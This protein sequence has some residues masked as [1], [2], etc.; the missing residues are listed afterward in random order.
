M[1][2]RK[3]IH[4]LG[5]FLLVIGG[6]C[7]LSLLSGCSTTKNTAAT[8]FYH[9]LTTRY[10]VL[11]HG[12]NA[13]DQ[14]YKNLI[15]GHKETYSE[16]IISDPVMMRRGDA[17]AGE[18]K[19]GPF[20]KSIEKGRKAI[21]YHSIRVKPERKRGRLSPKEEEF[22]NRKEFNSYL[23]HAWML[24]AKSQFYN[25][26]F[27]EAMASFAYIA[28]LYNT[29]P[30]IRDEARL[31]QARCYVA[32]GWNL[33]SQRILSQVDTVRLSSRSSVYPLVRVELALA[34]RDVSSAL[35]Y[36]PAA[37]KRESLRE[38]RSRLNFLHGQLLLLAEQSSLAQK[39]F[40]RVIRS[41][42]PYPLEFA[43]RLQKLRIQAGRSSEKVI[44]ELNRM[45]RS[46]KN[47]DFL[48]A[49]YL[50]KGDL[51]LQKK[52]T[53]SAVKAYTNGAEKST[54]KLFDYVLCELRR[55]DL[56]LFQE[57]FMRAQVAFSGAAAAISRQHESYDRVHTLSAQLDELSKHVKVVHEQDSLRHLASL[58]EAER[59][60]VIDSAIVT[61]KKQKEEEQKALEQQ[62]QREKQEQFNQEVGGWNNDTSTSSFPPPTMASD[63]RFYFYNPQLIAQGKTVFERK[64]GK[65]SLEDDWRRRTKRLAP[66]TQELQEQR[67]QQESAQESSMKEKQKAEKDQEGDGDIRVQSENPSED[68]TRREYYLAQLPLTPEKM[69][70]S[71]VLIQKA[72]VGMAEVFD[73]RM[74][75]FLSAIDSYTRLLERYPLYSERLAVYYSL[76]MLYHRIDMPQKAE[77]WKAKMLKEF[78]K[79]LLTLAVSDPHYIQR[80]QQSIDR[81]D[82]LYTQA[83]NSYMQGDVQKVHAAYDTLKNEYP[84]SPL[85]PQM[86]FVNGLAY[87]LS[88]NSAK[89]RLALED[90]IANYGK[91]EITFLSQ[92]ILAQLIAGRKLSR[93]GYT[94]IDRDLLFSSDTTNLDDSVSF[95]L[96]PSFGPHSVLLIYPKE[97]CNLN[98]LLFSV[99]GFNFS[100]FTQQVLELNHAVT[101]IREEL[102][103]GPFSSADRAWQ[104]VAK[105]YAPDGYMSQMPRGATLLVFDEHNLNLLRQGA[106]IDN[107]F[108]FVADS[109]APLYEEA[110]IPLTRRL[111]YQQEKEN[112]SIKADSSSLPNSDGIS[113]K[114]STDTLVNTRPITFEINRDML[115]EQD[116][117]VLDT[118]PSSDGSSSLIR[119]NVTESKPIT[120][121]K[122]EEM[123]NTRIRSEREIKKTKEKEQKERERLR[124]ERQKRKKEEQE[125]KRKLQ[126]ELQL[127]KEQERKIKLNQ[128]QQAQK[129]RQ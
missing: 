96:S 78:P 27:L 5:C 112:E 82:K 48:D 74:E 31:W 66:S 14:A 75:R 120:M 88:G 110:N 127:K 114:E 72:F 103:I 55:G 6:G 111:E 64:W 71:D 105:A 73:Q 118:V 39:A 70:E 85:L 94:G 60:I 79:D 26:N 43:S 11:F 80:L 56:F 37:I 57:D 35:E 50:I 4:W 15:T 81:E 83:F 100:Q 119:R 17:Q 121:D 84:L 13:Y 68:P 86:T 92:E 61:Y 7:A 46:D 76:F 47:K 1:S 106:S 58:P 36:M 54:Q 20:D 38:Q 109:I 25:G 93:A 117:L 65:R 115:I 18:T 3:N 98:N 44:R 90:I 21:R 10:N 87:V 129:K 41:A 49:I 67:D 33:D 104:Y 19:S 45:A 97:S 12:T 23:H 89:F 126:R 102:L 9:N 122:I 40:D 125:E 69:Q 51:H 99:A 42:P 128:R 124:A 29:Q 77:I 107:Y 8:R 91:A 62:K 30:V 59:L 32:M 108:Q 22:F 116:S 34:N 113:S 63:G 28:R 53:V 123:E 101:P 2:C 95:T 24:V 52:D 16:L